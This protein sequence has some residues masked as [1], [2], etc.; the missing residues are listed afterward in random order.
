MGR[1]SLYSPEVIETLCERI[2]GG[3][4]MADVCRDADMPAY[5]TVKD[6]IDETDDGGQA[7][8]RA[9]L[10]SAAIAR[11]RE[12]LEESIALDIM[13]I[14]DDGTQDFRQ[15]KNG[16]VFDSEHVQRSKLRI[17]V[18]FR[19]LAKMNPAKWGDKVQHADAEGG[20]LPAAPQFIVQGVAPTEH[21]DEA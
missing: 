18:R 1:P 21:P 20:K 17:D 14:A 19:L 5:R 10:V 15:G 9:L 7:T 4:A 6:W 13:A 11:A 16:P 12:E 3:R 8:E 2:R